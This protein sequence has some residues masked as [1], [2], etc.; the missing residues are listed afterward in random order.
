MPRIANEPA[1]TLRWERVG[2]YTAIRNARASTLPSWRRDGEG[3]R[4]ERCARRVPMRGPA[5]SRRRRGP[6][7]PLQTAEHDLV[8][9]LFAPLDGPDAERAWRQARALWRG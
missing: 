2:S 9:H 1:P 3:H 8:V 5:T 6:W 4:G 7:M